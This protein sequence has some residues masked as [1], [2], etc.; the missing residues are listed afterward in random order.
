MIRHDA[1]EA[2][3]EHTTPPVPEVLP[4]RG[5]G[6]APRNLPLAGRGDAAGVIALWQA[7]ARLV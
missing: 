1:A 6:F 5:G 4:F 7:G 2:E 3:R